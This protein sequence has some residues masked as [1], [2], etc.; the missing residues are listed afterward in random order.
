MAPLQFLKAG[1]G[2]PPQH[3]GGSDDLVRNNFR[4]AGMQIAR[5]EVDISMLYLMIA[6][7]HWWIS[8]CEGARQRPC[9]C[10]GFRGDYF[11]FKT[12]QGVTGWIRHN[13]ATETADLGQA[14]VP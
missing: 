12:V 13:A 9:R 8:G 14:I 2:L 11:K 10:A 6:D 1:R 3:S 4:F 7:D 5:I